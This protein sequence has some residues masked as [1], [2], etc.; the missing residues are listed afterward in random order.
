MNNYSGLYSSGTALLLVKCTA[1][2]NANGFIIDN[3]ANI[4]ENQAFD[5]RLYG[6]SLGAKPTQLVDKNVS[7]GNRTNWSGLTDCTTGLNTP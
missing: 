3:S 4:L 7:A 5:N 6:F 2:S 1:I